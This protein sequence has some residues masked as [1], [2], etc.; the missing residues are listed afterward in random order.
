MKIITFRN[1]NSITTDQWHSLTEEEKKDH[2]EFWREI[3]PGAGWFRCP[4]CGYPTH[5]GMYCGH[6]K[7]SSWIPECLGKPA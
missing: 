3:M 4:G 6:Q 1:L 7:C 5:R 2:D